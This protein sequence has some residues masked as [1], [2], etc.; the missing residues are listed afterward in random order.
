[1]NTSL[2]LPGVRGRL[3]IR[4]GAQ[5]FDALEFS[6]VTSFSALGP[7]VPAPLPVPDP[8]PCLA[9]LFAFSCTL[10]AE[11]DSALG[12]SSRL[13][14][15]TNAENQGLRAG[16]PGLAPSGAQALPE[17]VGHAQPPGGRALVL[18]SLCSFACRARMPCS[19]HTSLRYVPAPFTACARSM[20]V[21]MLLSLP[22]TATWQLFSFEPH[23]SRG[24]ES[25]SAAHHGLYKRRGP[26]G[27]SLRR[28]PVIGC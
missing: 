28:E 7:A 25:L 19:R 3:P 26:G 8:R 15:A 9:L 13:L 18:A 10:M 16:A 12:S 2:P 17:V 11:T 22:R 5:P 27:P 6:S 21:A 4:L 20:R 23:R 24:A 14:L 1:M